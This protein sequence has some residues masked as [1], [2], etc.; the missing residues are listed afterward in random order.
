MGPGC[1]SLFGLPFLLAGLF[2]SGFY[3]SGYVEWMR[4]QGWEQTPCR[5]ITVDLEANEDSDGVTTHKVSA[6]YEY[7]HQ[8][9]RFTGNRVSIY[10]G[11]DNIG[12]FQRRAYRELE[13]HRLSSESSAVPTFQCYVN[14]NDP[15]E[16][17]LYHILRWEMQCFMAIFAL[18]FPAVGTGLVVGGL[19]SMRLKKR[20][21]AL[22]AAHPDE[23]WKARKQWSGPSIRESSSPWQL[24]LHA[25]TGWS[26]LVIA[27]LMIFT[28]ASG[29]YSSQPLSWLSLIFVAAWMVPAWFSIR[30]WQQIRTVGRTRFRPDSTPFR[31]GD[32]VAGRLLMTHMPP[33]RLPLEATLLCEKKITFLG[34]DGKET[35]TEKVWE[36]HELIHLDGLGRE[37]DGYSVPLGIRL[38]RDAPESGSG[39]DGQDTEHIWKLAYRI[40]GTAV[41][42]TFEIP[43]FRTDDSGGNGVAV[44]V[45]ATAGAPSMLDDSLAYLPERL[46]DHHICATFDH[47]NL[48]TRLV[49]P[50]CRNPLMLI[51]LVLFNLVWTTAAVW[52]VAARAPWLFRII[53]PVTATGIWLQ[54]LWLLMHK[55]DVMVTA[56]SI[57]IVNQL[58]PVAWSRNFRK[59][60]IMGFDHHNSVRSGNS[61]SYKVRLLASS[62]RK[63]DLVDTITS[64]ATAKALQQRMFVWLERA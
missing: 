36:H 2:L 20:E 48:P 8:G 28:A 62:G 30:R 10:E 38:P 34:S 25:Y 12:S 60:E 57:R 16:S 49:S 9:R 63:C 14:P 1:L 11:S 13:S 5:I 39:T 61:N 21:D 23:P 37:I 29:A 33:M 55:R 45:T 43:V 7:L 50:P 24:A 15:R 4:I 42:G 22:A 47:E 27:P 6:T 64:S 54:V 17:V 18:T 3:F 31:P 41:S 58:G 56:D 40:P 52:L 59:D 26:A 35:S 53:W 46:R 51:L 19:I 44:P 32:L